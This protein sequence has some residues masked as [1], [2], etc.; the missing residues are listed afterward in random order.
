MLIKDFLNAKFIKIIWA[1]AFYISSCHP[2]QNSMN[3]RLKIAKND[4]RN[5]R[6]HSPN[7]SLSQEIYRV[8]REKGSG[9]VVSAVQE[10]M[11]SL[12]KSF[13]VSGNL[14]GNSWKG[15]GRCR[16]SCSGIID[17]TP[18]NHSLYRE[19]FKNVVI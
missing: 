19:I 13:I 17:V 6:C 7:H 3:R 18:Q 10:S 12:P 15:F 1:P 16:L 4:L 9:D 8:I 5:H 14:Q 2:G 11:M